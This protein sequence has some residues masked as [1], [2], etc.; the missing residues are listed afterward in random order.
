M[1][2]LFFLFPIRPSLSGI[3][4]IVR[5]VHHAVI[6]VLPAIIQ[7]KTQNASLKYDRPPGSIMIRSIKPD[8]IQALT[9]PD[10]NDQLQSSESEGKD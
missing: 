6:Q 3:N 1:S 7:V 5:K 4:V 8:Y 10:K 2:S 9:L